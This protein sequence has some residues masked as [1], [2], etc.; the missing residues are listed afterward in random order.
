MDENISYKE[1][2]IKKQHSL[3]ELRNL[4]AKSLSK[5]AKTDEELKKEIPGASYEE[6]LSVIKNMLNLKLI[7]KEGYPV[8]YFLSDEILKTLEKR[9][10]LSEKD[11]HPIRVAIMIESKSDSKTA[12]RE[13]MEKIEDSLKKDNNYFVYDSSLA[14]IVVHDDLF[15]TYLSAEVSCADLFNLFRLIYFYGVTSIDVLKPEKLH[16]PVSDLQNSLQTI[17]DM[18]HGYADI[19]YNLKKKNEILSK[20]LK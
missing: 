13:A 15:S 10:E 4:I 2:E 5:G 19:I 6:L 9:K 16:V 12:L 11:T 7:K 1:E 8:K 14:E 3:L 17:V 20:N 18:V